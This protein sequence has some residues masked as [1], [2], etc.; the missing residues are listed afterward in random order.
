MGLHA[1]EQDIEDFVGPSDSDIRV[2][3]EQDKVNVTS[4]RV[5]PQ[6]ENDEGD[7]RNVPGTQSVWIKT[8]GCSHNT[9]DSEVRAKHTNVPLSYATGAMPG[10][11]QDGIPLR[12]YPKTDLQYKLLW[13]SP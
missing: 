9:S 1:I 5:R 11:M 4:R 3:R 2:P 10:A 7:A 8:F 6:I 13:G 12:C